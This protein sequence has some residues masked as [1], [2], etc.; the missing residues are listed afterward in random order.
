MLKQLHMKKSPSSLDYFKCIYPIYRDY[1]IRHRDFIRKLP[2]CLPLLASKCQQAKVTSVKVIDV[3]MRQAHVMMATDDKVKIIHLIRDPRGVLNS[4]QVF[5]VPESRD[6]D[7]VTQFCARVHEDVTASKTLSR[8]FPGRILT[9]RYED[10]VRSPIA[11]TEQLYAFVGIDPTSG[12]KDKIWEMTY[13]GL[14]DGCNVCPT[15]Q[16]ATE[17]ANRWRGTLKF[18]TVAVIQEGC[19]ELLA[20]MGYRSFVTG[21]EQLNNHIHSTRDD[22]DRDLMKIN[23]GR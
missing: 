17:T 8:L 9:V 14:P 7:Y 3:N 18:E 21:E 10:I 19:R 5:G 15:R 20:T 11:V 13:G 4:R 1:N 23:L 12:I 6:P 22:Y 16:N 2:T